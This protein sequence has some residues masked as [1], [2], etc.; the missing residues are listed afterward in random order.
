MQ[1]IEEHGFSA[2]V[3]L[4]ENPPELSVW[5]VLPGEDGERLFE[6]LSAPK[7]ALICVAADWN[8]DLS[9]WAAKKVFRGGEDFYGGANDFLKNL[10][11][12]IIPF[13]ENKFNITNCK[14][15][16]A[17]YS[18]AGLF[19][20]YAFYKTAAFFSG[21]SVSGSLWYD[22]FID[23]AKSADFCRTPKRFYFSVGDRESKTKNSRMAT[24][25]DC[26]RAAAELF[27]S[28]GANVKFE[29]NPGGHFE[30]PEKRLAA[31]IAFSMS[32]M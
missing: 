31:G 16:I 13:V 1:K 3:F 20:A 10:V 29:L 18:L 32:C 15:I 28:R 11:E 7:P 30:N 19:S 12:N 17:G 2:T 27:R 14:R 4:P 22:G 26:T 6:L 25:E 5:T 21:A 8:R 9:P 23:F 24:V